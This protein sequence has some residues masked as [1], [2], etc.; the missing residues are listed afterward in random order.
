M[1][2]RIANTGMPDE[3]SKQKLLSMLRQMW[4]IRI[5]ETTVYDLLGQNIIKGA[6]HLYAGEEAVAVGAVAALRDDDLITSTHR[7]HG[8]CLARG[9]SLVTGD[10]AI[11]THLNKMMAELCGRATGYCGGRGGSMHIA[12]VE[13]GN[14][15]AT[16]IVGGNIPVATGAAL[17]MKL[18]GMDR[19]VAC[20]FGDGATNTGNF[21]EAL[22]LASAWHLPVVYIVENNLYGMSVPFEK[23]SPLPDVAARAAAYDMPGVVLDGMD[24]IAVYEGVSAALQRAR[25]GL[26]PTLIECKTYRWYGHSRSDP[27]VYRTKEEEQAWHNRDAIP[28]FADRL[29]ALGIA[30]RDEVDAVEAAAEKAIA[31]ATE[32]ALASPMPAPAE[33][34]KDVYVLNPPTPGQVEAE[35]R[36]RERVRTDSSLPVKN[37]WEAIRDALREELLRDPGVFVMGEDVALYGGA[38]GATR[39]LFK[40]FGEKRVFD[41][42]ISEALI[43]GMAVGAAMT[44]MRPVGEIMYVDFTPLAMDQIANQGAKNRYMFGGKTRVPMVIRTEG[45]AGRSIAAHHSQSLEALWTHFP[46]IYVV[47]PSTP[48]DAKGL[49]KSAI[50]DD[51]PVMFIEHK[52][53]YGTKGPVPE[54]DYTIPLGVADVKREGSDVTLISY[55][56]MVLR[57]LEAAEELAAEGISVEVIDLRTLKPL[58]METVVASV[59]KTGRVVGVTEGY[60]TGSF[61]SEL[62]TCINE[63]AFDYLDAPMVRVAAADVPVPMAETLE[64]AAI[65]STA[66]IIAGVRR[67][68]RHA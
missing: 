34:E 19:C 58:D 11:Q 1:T 45:G 22:N 57:C 23:V 68:L 37:Y 65:P 50:R 59:R 30:T 9:E 42:P 10:E 21:H 38:Y 13:K 25:Q 52:M 48:Y 12:D 49:L 2:D 55:S 5:F 15:G 31:T 24:P 27:R 18:Q 46:G 61:I 35:K 20:F 6:S 66:A 14:L 4:E 8:H 36:L 33:V 40:E 54:E 28:A 43:G 47:M 16:G 39:G 60:K 26:G 53:L 44:G 62:F 3:L 29:V 7:G 32:F 67:V 41:T 56:R 17:S 63:S 51:N 64:D